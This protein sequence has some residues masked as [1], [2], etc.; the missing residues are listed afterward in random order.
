MA[1]PGVVVRRINGHSLRVLS[2]K[3][4]AAVAGTA[5]KVQFIVRLCAR[6]CE[7]R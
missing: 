6:G 2:N 3:S 7:L 4:H 1:L 5:C